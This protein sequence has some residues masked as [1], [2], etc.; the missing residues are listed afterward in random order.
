MT[1]YRIAL[2]AN[3][4]VPPQLAA[5]GHGAAVEEP[6]MEEAAEEEV[7]VEE[8]TVE[9]M[10]AEEEP[11]GEGAV[12][13]GVEE[14]P[15]GGRQQQQ[16][17]KQGCQWRCGRGGGTCGAWASGEGRSGGRCQQQRSAEVQW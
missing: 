12:G 7:P 3:G 2:E 10:G 1:M 16:W 11:V 13:E 17:C 15:V 8:V 9:E 5:F 6:V 14:L 4:L